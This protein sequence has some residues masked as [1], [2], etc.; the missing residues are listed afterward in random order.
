MLYS[1]IACC[2]LKF[3]MTV[4]GY[5]WGG[6]FCHSKWAFPLS[7]GLDPCMH[8]R[9]SFSL[10]WTSSILCERLL[11]EPQAFFMFTVA[12]F[13]FSFLLWFSTPKIDHSFCLDIFLFLYC[14]MKDY[15]LEHFLNFG[16]NDATRFV[17]A[18]SSYQYVVYTVFFCSL[19]SFLWLLYQP[20]C[21]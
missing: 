11:L 2:W 12:A 10:F 13:I 9:P 19:Y 7:C 15:M 3:C 4:S 16:I 14:T 20:E 21:F 8:S 5:K 18:F 1:C 17:N 6:S